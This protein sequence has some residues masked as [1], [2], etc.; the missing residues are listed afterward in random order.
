[1]VFG[2]CLNSLTTAARERAA[3][4]RNGLSSYNLGK[5]TVT[6]VSRPLF[7]LKPTVGFTPVASA[8]SASTALAC[9][10]PSVAVLTT[11]QPA[12]AAARMTMAMA[13]CMLFPISFALSTPSSTVERLVLT[14]WSPPALRFSR[15]E[16]IHHAM[17][18]NRVAINSEYVRWMSR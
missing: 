12:S 8:M 14:A 1:M 11:S 9:L 17:D 15:T 5:L 4:S 16:F 7:Q 10:K 18:Y 13:F 3:S 6:D 2:V